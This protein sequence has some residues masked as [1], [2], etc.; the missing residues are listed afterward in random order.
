MAWLKGPEGSYLTAT[1]LSGGGYTASYKGESI[2][3]IKRKRD[4]S[5]TINPS[6]YC[7]IDEPTQRALLET[8]TI[9]A[10]REKT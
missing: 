7:S 2:G 4:G 8:M 1:S 5:W 10:D 9:V 6:K 3:T